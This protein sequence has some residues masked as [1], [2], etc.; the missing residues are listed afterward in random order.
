MAKESG[1]VTLTRAV[2]ERFKFPKGSMSSAGK[3]IT[4][5]FLWDDVARGFGVRVTADGTKSYIAQGRVK[6]GS[7]DALRL[8]V[9]SVGTET[10]EQAR[11]VAREYLRDMRQ[12]IDPRAKLKRNKALEI[13]LRQVADAYKRDRQLKDSTKGEIERHVTTTFEAWLNKPLLAVTRADVTERYNEM[14][15]RGLRGKG[16]APGQANQAFAVLRAMFN[17]AINEY[18]EADGKALFTDNP[19]DVLKKKIVRLQPRK[20]CIP[21]NKIGAVWVALEKARDEAR[22]GHML[23][24]IHLVMF[25]LLTGA[26]IGEASALEW[27]SKRINLTEEDNGPWWHLPDPKNRNPVWL[28]LSTQ[29]VAL[30]K[31]RQA[32]ARKGNPYVF[33][34]WRQG[35]KTYMRDPRERMKK[36]S[37]VAGLH[38]SA[39]DIRRSFTTIGRTLCKIDLPAM[40]LLTNHLP[41]GVT[42]E[43]YVETQELHYLRPEVQ[44]IADYITEQARIARAKEEATN[45]VELRA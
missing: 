40:Q 17:Y 33:P 36:V 37:E 4:Q 26:R 18:R 27:D 31:E 16:P 15:D 29:A 20:R 13:T 19:C 1:R 5:A 28:P 3:P 30:L 43:H 22:D 10:V 2:V 41:R 14:R 21:S 7:A 25:L 9:G 35:G 23:T 32:A 8:K 44:Q 34:S 11:E 12:G 6:G 45:V 42:E 24:G 39:H 38:L